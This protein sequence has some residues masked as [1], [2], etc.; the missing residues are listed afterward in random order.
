MGP[1]KK[2]ELTSG[3]EAS[4]PLL[5]TPQN[6]RPARGKSDSLLADRLSFSGCDDCKSIALAPDLFAYGF[7]SKTA[8]AQRWGSFEPPR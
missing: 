7:F 1:G 2:A 4:K 6:S 8:E 3:G 5:T